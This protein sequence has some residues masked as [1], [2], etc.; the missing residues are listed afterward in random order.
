MILIKPTIIHKLILDWFMKPLKNTKS[1]FLKI[2]IKIKKN[3]PHKILQTIINPL[4]N[5]VSLSI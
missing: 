2:N 1:L 5:K 4:N 3:L